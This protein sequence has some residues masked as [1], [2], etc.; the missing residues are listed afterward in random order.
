MCG[1]RCLPLEYTSIHDIRQGGFHMVCDARV[2]AGRTRY[3]SVMD[4]KCHA[5]RVGRP[6]DPLHVTIR[7]K[8]TSG[9]VDDAHTF[10]L[11]S[12]AALRLRVRSNDLMSAYRRL[13]HQA[14]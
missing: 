10:I 12:V 1:G 3:G 7:T 6:Q 14:H 4:G 9:G 13:G 5:H 2:A 8:A 11:G